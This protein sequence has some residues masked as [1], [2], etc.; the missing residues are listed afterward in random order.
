MSR[1]CAFGLGLTIGSV[2]GA[3]GIYLGARFSGRHFLDVTTK[4]IP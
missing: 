2:A 4:E 3:L 1:P